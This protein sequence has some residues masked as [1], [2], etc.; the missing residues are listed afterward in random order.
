MQTVIRRISLLTKEFFKVPF[1]DVLLVCALAYLFLYSGDIYRTRDFLD[2]SFQCAENAV[3]F[4]SSFLATCTYVGLALFMVLSY[5]FTC[6]CRNHGLSELLDI[7]ENRASTI[8]A[9]LFFLSVLAILYWTFICCLCLRI[10]IATKAL[11]SPMTAN[12]LLASMLYGFLPALAG[13]LLGSAGQRLGG[14]VGFFIFLMFSV[15]FST[16]MSRDFYLT[17]C[18]MFAEAGNLPAGVATQ[19]ILDFW[20]RMPPVYN[21]ITSPVYGIGIEPFHWALVIFWCLLGGGILLIAAHRRIRKGMGMLCFVAAL[22][23]ASFVWCRGSNWPEYMVTPQER[24]VVQD[25][26]WY[27][28]HGTEMEDEEAGFSVTSY[29]MDLR[30]FSE[31]DADV[32]LHLAGPD[33]TACSFTLYHGFTIRQITDNGGNPM[34]Y[35]RN[36]DYIIVNIPESSEVS[37]IRFRYSGWHDSLFSTAQGIYLPG[38]FCFYPLPGKRT[39]YKDGQI[40][41]S[42]KFMEPC[43]FSVRVHA[44][45]PVFSNL[46]VQAD[47]SFSGTATSLSLIGGLYREQTV[48]SVR[49]VI[50]WWMEHADYME[51]LIQAIEEINT[52]KELEIPLP[53]YAVVFYSPNISLP[54][55]RAGACTATKDALF[56][57]HSYG[58]VQ[59]QDLVSAY[60]QSLAAQ[61]V[62]DGDLDKIRSLWEES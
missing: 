6:R 18:G 29:S 51:R 57:G 15:F 4:A 49:Y 59:V 2:T 8:A 52:E 1:F 41:F 24:I 47:G 21:N 55:R 62:E 13:V 40:V 27:A 14:R 48:G 61:S 42:H 3:V 12:F 39:V 44:L 22:L 46:N 7:H 5:E 33:L 50:P 10:L 28:E 60:L 34:N 54:T 20:F 56:V 38:Y 11:G 35:T 36:G 26:A 30:F 31:L 23:C 37:D 43:H 32:T 53:S 25:A 45:C 16:Q 19:K 17:V 58:G 9:Q